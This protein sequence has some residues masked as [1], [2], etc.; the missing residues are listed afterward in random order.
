MPWFTTGAVT[1]KGSLGTI[2]GL[3][4]AELEV[5]TVVDEEMAPSE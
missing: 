3:Q 1:V 4:L 5:W 2:S